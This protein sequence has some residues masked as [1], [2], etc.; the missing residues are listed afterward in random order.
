MSEA[1]PMVDKYICRDRGMVYFRKRGCRKVR[2]RQREGT[3]E[4]HRR[5]AELLEQAKAGALRP[6]RV[7]E[8]K[9]NTWRWLCVQFFASETG[10]LKLD[11]ET[12]HVRRRVLEST[13]EEPIAP[14]MRETFADCPLDRMSGKAV[15]ILRGRKRAVPDAANTRVK[16]IS[17][18]WAWAIEEEIGG[19]TTNPARD[20]ARLRSKRQGGHHAWTLDEVAQYEQHHPRGTKAHLALS[21]LINTGCRRGDV[22]LLGRRHVRDGW[23]KYTQQKNRKHNPVPVDIPLLPALRDVID[24]S[25]SATS[26]SWSTTT[27]GGR[28]PTPASAIACESG[29][30][31]RG[32]RIARHTDCARPLRPSRR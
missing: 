22:I 5:Y 21:L 28:S 3:P 29:A 30:K 31:R 4:F 19:V 20:V 16:A 15:R 27:T 12:R 17:R 10:L 13:W 1:L 6:E 26:P 2:I 24:A 23:L 8:P 32:C 11:A 9:P 25:R 14:G 18:V 7:G